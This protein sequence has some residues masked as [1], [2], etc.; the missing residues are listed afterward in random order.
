MSS[1]LTN[2]KSLLIKYQNNTYGQTLKGVQTFKRGMLG[3]NTV[4]PAISVVPKTEVID[5]IRSGGRYKVHREIDIEVVVRLLNI[6]DTGKYTQELCQSIMDM[7]FDNSHSDNYEMSDL[8]FSFDLGQ[9]RY[10]SFEGDRGKFLQKGT[11]PM[12]FKSW[13]TIPTVTNYSTITET[14]TRNI[15]E[16]IYSILEADNLLSK[17]KFFYSHSFPPIRIGSGIAVCVLETVDE[18][19]RRETSRDNPL[20]Y[21]DIMVWTKASPHE[22]SLD[23]NLETVETIKDV[24]QK[25]VFMGGKVSNSRI[26][27]INFGINHSLQ[28]Y[29]SQI[30]FIT[31]GR[32]TLPSY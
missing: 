26:D 1:L 2:Y 24:L 6:Q 29:G 14:D 5:G 11:I 16:H 21:Y 4:F 27:R 28:L 22:G 7:F 8:C 3:K 19:T 32:D 10:E 23:L 12:T 25:D 30:R 9:I 13:E 15:G 20:G 31:Q 17:V 18:K